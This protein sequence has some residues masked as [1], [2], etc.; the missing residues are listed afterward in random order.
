M[1]NVVDVSKKVKSQQDL[2]FT[3]GEF[4][5]VLRVVKET[6]PG[7]GRVVKHLQDEMKERHLYIFNSCWGTIEIPE[8]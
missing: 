3:L 6:N 2:L 5:H 7:V 1:K 4:E 8:V